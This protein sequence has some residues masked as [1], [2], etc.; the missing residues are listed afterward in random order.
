MSAG[1]GY[2][3][4]FLDAQNCYLSVVFVKPWSWFRTHTFAE[5]NIETVFIAV[6]RIFFLKRLVFFDVRSDTC[7]RFTFAVFFFYDS[8]IIEAEPVDAI[9]QL[10]RTS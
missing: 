7:I 3:L 6:I 8:G 9:D 2:Y 4:V 5:L 1:K 10:S